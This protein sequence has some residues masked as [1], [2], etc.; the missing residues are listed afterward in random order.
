MALRVMR[1]R[2]INGAIS[3]S[4]ELLS[5]IEPSKLGDPKGTLSDMRNR[6]EQ[7]IHAGTN[8]EATQFTELLSNL[9]R[10]YWPCP[11][12]TSKEI[13]TP[14]FNSHSVVRFSNLCLLT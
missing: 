3:S 5:A 8:E 12:P 2:R 13:N 6:F 10:L 14:N 1:L 7:A 11:T 9:G 4:E